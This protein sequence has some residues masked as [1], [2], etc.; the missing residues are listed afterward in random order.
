MNM[1]ST[2]MNKIAIPEEARIKELY[3]Q[4]SLRCSRL[5]QLGQGVRKHLSATSA[6]DNPELILIGLRL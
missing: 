3:E 2:A 6:Y 5:Q 4:I 1:S